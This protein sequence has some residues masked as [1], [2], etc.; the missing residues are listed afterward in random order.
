MKVTKQQ[1]QDWKAQYG[2]LYQLPVDDKVAYLKPPTMKEY[3]LAFTQMQKHGNVA[4]GESLLG[5]L[6]VGGDKEI[7]EVFEYSNS[8]RRTLLDFFDYPDAVIENAGDFA[9]IKIGE[10][11]CKVHQVQRHHLK[12]AEKQNPN[13]RIF[14]TE[15]RLFE[16][17]KV[18]A[19]VAFDDVNVPEIRMPLYQAIERLQNKKVAEL[20]KL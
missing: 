6:F 12:K 14:V 18:E 7:I 19:D 3:K 2:G 15:E 8:A 20:K 11:T 1:I 10:H 5:S 16:I 4:Y 13:D 17:I 9:I